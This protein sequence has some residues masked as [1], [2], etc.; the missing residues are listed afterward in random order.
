MRIHITRLRDLMNKCMCEPCAKV[1]ENVT[2]KNRSNCQPNSF[3]ESRE[4][5]GVRSGL[6]TQAQRPGARDVWTAT[7]TLPPGSLQRMVRPQSR[8]VSIGHS[9]LN[10]S[11]SVS[12]RQY[13][14]KSPPVKVCAFGIR[15][16]LA[17]TVNLT[18]V[19]VASS[20]RMRSAS[21]DTSPH[22]LGHADA[23]P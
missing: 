11:L 4:L 20:W 6:T 22:A 8:H 17:L 14:E 13:N 2:C 18:S 16:S 12:R 15:P 19:H 23:R 21:S 10:D 7:A 1:T 3:R 5:H 9:D